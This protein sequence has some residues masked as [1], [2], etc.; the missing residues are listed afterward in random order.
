MGG[1]GNDN[2]RFEYDGTTTNLANYGIDRI[3][4]MNASGDDTIQLDDFLFAGITN[5]NL[6]NT[7]KFGSV[8]TDADD[9]IIYDS[10]TGALY[11]DSNGNAA[12]GVT[13]IG[14]LDAGTV[15]TVADFS[16]I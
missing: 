15:L 5:A 12:G 2:F 14:Q 8:A 7:V 1:G 9:R 4:D 16:V 6:V 13:Q 10:V 11:Y 3:L